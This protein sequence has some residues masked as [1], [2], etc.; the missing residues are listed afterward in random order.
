VEKK[1]YTGTLAASV[2]HLPAQWNSKSTVYF[3]LTGT[4]FT[5]QL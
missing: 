4:D 2:P 3:G 1:S 5:I